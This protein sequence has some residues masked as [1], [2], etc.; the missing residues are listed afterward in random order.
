[1]KQISILIVTLN[2][3]LSGTVLPPNDLSTKYREEQKASTNNSAQNYTKYLNVGVGFP[4]LLHIASA[5]EKLDSRVL[6]GYELSTSILI[7][8]FSYYRQIKCNNYID[9]GLKPGIFLIYYLPIGV[10]FGAP[11]NINFTEK[12]YLII[13][14]S[15]N[16]F[17]DL[18]VIGG[19]VP[20]IDFSLVY[21]F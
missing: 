12:T 8:R 5:H 11:L 18:F 20:C 4:F 3:L 7:S 13:N 10:S 14:P 16:Y 17:E 21:R 6:Y 1:M 9:F 15:L 2:I 19:F